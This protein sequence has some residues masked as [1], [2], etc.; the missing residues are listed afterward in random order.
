M[1]MPIGR[2]TSSQARNIIER[3]KPGGP[4]A[5]QLPRSITELTWA[6]AEPHPH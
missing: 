6:M 3:N 5:P 2:P 1:L 4:Q